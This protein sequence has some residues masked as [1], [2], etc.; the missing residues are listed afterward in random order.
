M[1]DEFLAVMSHEL[2]HPLNLIQLN[3]ELLMRLPEAQQLPAVT[4]RRQHHP[5]RRPP[6]RPRSSTTCWTCRACTPASSR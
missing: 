1:K 2:K 5:R 6:T 4:A 3:A